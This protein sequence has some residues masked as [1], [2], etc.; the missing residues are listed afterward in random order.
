MQSLSVS[1]SYT[2]PPNESLLPMTIEA[3]H[4]YMDVLATRDSAASS[5]PDHA[6]TTTSRFLGS[7]TLTSEIIPGERTYPVM[8]RCVY[9]PNT[10]SRHA[11]IYARLSTSEWEI[12][13]SL[14][15]IFG[16]SAKGGVIMNIA[17]VWMKAVR[18]STTNGPPTLITSAGT[19][20]SRRNFA[21]FLELL[22][23]TKQGIIEVEVISEEEFALCPSCNDQG[24]ADPAMLERLLTRCIDVRRVCVQCAQQQGFPPRAKEVIVRGIH[25]N[26]IRG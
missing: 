1:S 2:A 23:T 26:V 24:T 3:L 18:S 15:D 21:D 22:G 4:G 12:A 16:I 13:L 20:L 7:I 5:G 9:P 11:V 8:V 25:V 6:V 19:P 14:Y 17:S 10:Q